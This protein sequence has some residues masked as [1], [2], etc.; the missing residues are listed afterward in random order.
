M[1]DQDVGRCDAYLLPRHCVITITR[2]YPHTSHTNHTASSP[3]G[4]PALADI[5]PPQPTPP[6]P[7][8]PSNPPSALKILYKRT[9]R[10]LSSLQLAIAELAVIAALCAIGTVID[11]NMPMQFYQEV[12]PADGRLLDW[13][14]IGL[15]EWDH[16]YTCWYFLLLNAALALSLAACTSTRQ[17]PAI[18]VCGCVR[19]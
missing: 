9:L 6:Q 19:I 2:P 10:R 11:Q 15:L 7:T 1:F 17:I 8:P 3:G 18:K 4:A 5:P 13:R 12:Y 16:V 14:V